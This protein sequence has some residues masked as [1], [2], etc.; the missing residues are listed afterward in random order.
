MKGNTTNNKARHRVKTTKKG[1][2]KN[3]ERK[4]Y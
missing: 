3:F 1:I 2:S 4:R